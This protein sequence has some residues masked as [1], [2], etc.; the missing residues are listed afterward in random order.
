M[1]KIYSMDEIQLDDLDSIIGGNNESYSNINGTI[2]INLESA[3]RSINRV[4]CWNLHLTFKMKG[5]F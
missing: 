1:E 3:Q 4:W 5:C 2:N